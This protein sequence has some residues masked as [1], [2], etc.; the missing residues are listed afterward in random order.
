MLLVGLNWAWEMWEEKSESLKE[1]GSVTGFKKEVFAVE[2]A[3]KIST[4]R[5]KAG[6]PMRQERLF[7]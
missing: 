3:R 2:T 5:K 1:K 7:G 6:C 4:D